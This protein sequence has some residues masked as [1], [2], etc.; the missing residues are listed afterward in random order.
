VILTLN[1]RPL[2]A[3]FIQFFAPTTPAY[4]AFS[5]S[6]IYFLGNGQFVTHSAAMSEIVFVLGAGASVHTG[7]PVMA[8]FLEHA[9]LISKGMTKP[10]WKGHFDQ[11]FDAI[12]NL[13]RVHSKAY[14]D[15]HNLEAVFTILETARTI[16]K[17][18]GFDSE[19][20]PAVL[21]SFKQVITY[22]LDSTTRFT[23]PSDTNTGVQIQPSTDYLRFAQLVRKLQ[24]PRS[25]F[26]GVSIITFNYDIAL[27]LALLNRG[28]YPDYSLPR[29]DTVGSTIKLLKLHGSLNWGRVQNSE[30]IYYFDCLEDFARKVAL[31]LADQK[32]TNLPVGTNLK[33][34]VKDRWAVEI[35]PV[36]VIVP[37][38]FYKA[39][40]HEALKDVWRAA[41][42]EL[43][44]AEDIIV[45]GFSLPTTDS[46]FNHLYAL[47]TEGKSTIRK[48]W[49]F[50]P[51]NEGTV[52]E[53]FKRILGYGA[54]PHFHYFSVPFDHAVNEIAFQYYGRATGNVIVANT[55][56]G[57]R[58]YG[59]N[60]EDY[61]ELPLR[62]SS[63]IR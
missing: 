56:L 41:A 62:P 4:F 43:S 53:R 5:D 13:Q 50:N 40:H 48:F 24:N 9:R 33:S 25:G 28:I 20:I 35:E 3:V 11:V 17:L 54:S 26:N 63:Q 7:A 15:I 44:D 42:S 61:P 19:Q 32:T 59:R 39:E 6:D 30:D 60:I 31:S 36:P 27:D 29:R 21:E 14:F 57:Y 12:N 18:P 8:T 58:P 45:I 23:V 47:G 2:K 55:S 22:T 51:D 16:G 37:P 34:L 38:G 10:P 52:E 46:F 1:E 49:V